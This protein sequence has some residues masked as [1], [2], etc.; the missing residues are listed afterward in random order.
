MIVIIPHPSE[1]L[2]LIKY[3]KELISKLNKSGQ[4][5]YAVT[6]IYI[7]LSQDYS[8][9]STTKEL[10]NIANQIS[11]VELLKLEVKEH[12]YIEVL[13]RINEK[14]IKISVPFL[15]LYRTTEI[16][17]KVDFP[18]L[19]VK[20]LKIFR[21]AKKNLLSPVSSSIADS[22]WKKLQ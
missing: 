10:K 19:P 12:I 17:N 7:E 22:V 3:Q 14:D 6:P 11:K 8:L 18:E 21:V 1:E 16:N 2:K 15:R 5:Y 20:E 9:Y 13:I 4:I